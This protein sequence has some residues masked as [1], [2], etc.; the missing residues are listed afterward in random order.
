M[1]AAT[2]ILPVALALQLTLAGACEA[3]DALRE[4]RFQ[5]SEPT[6]ASACE[7]EDTAA[8]SKRQAVRFSGTVERS[9]LLG[10]ACVVQI[11]R[12]RFDALYRW[13]SVGHSDGVPRERYACW[14]MYS[15]THVTFLYAYT[16]DFY[17]A[18]ACEFTCSAR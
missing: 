17:G 10:V 1:T 12:R 5:W 11:A 3:A 16:D 4:L 15:P 18:P 14:V 8:G 13:C 7:L 6:P 9:E 2:P